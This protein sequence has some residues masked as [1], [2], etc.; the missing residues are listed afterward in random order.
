MLDWVSG[1]ELLMIVK[2]EPCNYFEIPP[3]G[4]VSPSPKEDSPAITI[5]PPTG[6]EEPHVDESRPL[7]HPH[8][9]PERLQTVGCPI[10]CCCSV[11]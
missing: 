8:R 6:M 3:T 1:V 5:S 11:L 7:S 10:Q 4:S 9:S 2:G